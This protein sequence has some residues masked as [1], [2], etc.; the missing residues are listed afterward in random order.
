M[1]S[2]EDDD[3]PA[4]TSR[5]TAEDDDGEGLIPDHQDEAPE[6]KQHHTAWPPSMD[7]T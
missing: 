2:I 5:K 7:V 3:I 4:D 1:R 6:R